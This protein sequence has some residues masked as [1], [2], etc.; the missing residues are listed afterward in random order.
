MRYEI[1]YG[2]FDALEL[3]E[4]LQ[5][6]EEQFKIERVRVIEVV[7]IVRSL[8]VLLVRQN[9][10]AAM[11]PSTIINQIIEVNLIQVLNLT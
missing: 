1:V 5:R 8:L 11:K 10:V 3:L 9:L 7:V 6:L 2:H 4:T